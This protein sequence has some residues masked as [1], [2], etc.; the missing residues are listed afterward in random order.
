MDKNIFIKNKKYNPDIAKN[1]SKVISDRDNSKY[2]FKDEFI[3]P[4]IVNK[5]KAVYKIDKESTQMDLM[6]NQRLQERDKQE[7]DFKPLKNTIP[8][9]NPNNFKE[10]SDLKN[11]QTNYEYNQK[12][13]DNNFNSI[14]SDLKDLGIL[15]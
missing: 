13:K 14:L 12:D 1:Y 7:F 2:T 4:D 5:D 15:K 10:F 6:I 9:S 11:Q 3:N 8:T